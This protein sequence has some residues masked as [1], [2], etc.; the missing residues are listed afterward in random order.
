MTFNP[1]DYGDPWPKKT[2][3]WGKF[4]PPEKNIVKIDPFQAGKITHAT[5]TEQAE[6]RSE[7]PPGF[8]KAFFKAN[9]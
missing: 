7:T 4:T 1:Y 8:A 3:L 9:P 6:I 5:G 2:C